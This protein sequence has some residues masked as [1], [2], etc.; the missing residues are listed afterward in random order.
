MFSFIGVLLYDV[1]L[2][3]FWKIYVWKQ[4]GLNLMP[5]NINKVL[6]WD[7]IECACLDEDGICTK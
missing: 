5:Q 6:K 2:E 3:M 4:H 7:V 1:V